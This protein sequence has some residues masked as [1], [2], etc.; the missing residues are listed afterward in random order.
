MP[1]EVL[2]Q[3][4]LQTSPPPIDLPEMRKE[5]L[6]DLEVLTYLKLKSQ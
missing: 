1:E 5:S 2:V 6:K 4:P 3:L